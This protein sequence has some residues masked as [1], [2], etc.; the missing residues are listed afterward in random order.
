ML[1][2]LRLNQ[3]YKNVMNSDL[4]H[5]SNGFPTLYFD[6]IGLDVLQVATNTTHLS[7]HHS[8]KAAYVHAMSLCVTSGAP[9]SKT[10]CRLLIVSS[11]YRIITML[12]ETCSA[13]HIVGN[14]WRTSPLDSPRH[15]GR[16]PWPVALPRPPKDLKSGNFRRRERDAH[17]VS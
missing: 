13:D 5:I 9:H 1:S 7:Q 14:V 8:P 10:N 17:E 11:K 15:L 3:I 2:K 16:P 4:S 12:L 6:M